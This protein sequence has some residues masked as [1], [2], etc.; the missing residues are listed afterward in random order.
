MTATECT[1]LLQNG[2][3]KRVNNNNNKV[4]T[5][6]IKH[7]DVRGI[8]PHTLSTVA[9]DGGECSAS[10]LG[11]YICVIRTDRLYPQE[12]LLVLISVRG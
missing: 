12:M 8:S 5:W 9:I 10:R 3:L 1:I 7:R 4:T 6:L 11:L 2:V